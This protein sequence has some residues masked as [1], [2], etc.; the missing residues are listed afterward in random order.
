MLLPTELLAIAEA[1]REAFEKEMRVQHLLEQL[2]VQTPR[3]RQWTGNGLVW[4]GSRL[5]SWGEG[6]TMT[7]GSQ[8]VEVLH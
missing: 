1:R 2:P 3:W 5:V 8:G 7:N 6:M 4:A